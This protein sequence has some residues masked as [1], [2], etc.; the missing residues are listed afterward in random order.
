MTKNFVF[1]TDQ[2]LEEAKRRSV[3]KSFEKWQEKA[4]LD[5][6]SH[7]NKS[8]YRRFPGNYIKIVRNNL[9]I[10]L[11][12]KTFTVDGIEMRIYVALRVF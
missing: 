4:S 5:G 8:E 6:Y 7:G 9:R 10:I 2:F 3:L 11:S 1:T 12:N